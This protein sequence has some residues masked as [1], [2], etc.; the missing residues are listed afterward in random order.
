MDNNQSNDQKICENV[1]IMLNQKIV[2]NLINDF[3]D[4][5]VNVLNKAFNMTY[6]DSLSNVRITR[7]NLRKSQIGLYN[8]I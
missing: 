2:R 8:P 7:C 1:R 3:G 4:E 6:Q 5:F